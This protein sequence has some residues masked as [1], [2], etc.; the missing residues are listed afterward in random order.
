[1]LARLKKERIPRDELATRGDS[2]IL[3]RTVAFQVARYAPIISAVHMG[4]NQGNTSKASAFKLS[5]KD[6]SSLL[7][8][9]A[10]HTCRELD[11]VKI[12][13]DLLPLMYR[14]GLNRG[15]RAHKAVF[16]YQHIGKVV[17]VDVLFAGHITNNEELDV[18]VEAMCRILS[19]HCAT[20]RHRPVSTA[21][22]AYERLQSKF[23]TIRRLIAEANVGYYAIYP[24]REVE[25]D[26][27]T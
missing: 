21:D 9:V 15:A 12:R 2:S 16:D 26:L 8:T 13:C 18:F 20:N 3:D 25:I 14:I 1:M 4:L 7:V 19:N 10:A 5:G 22:Q 17:L 23:S 27:S 24:Y 11:P 6:E